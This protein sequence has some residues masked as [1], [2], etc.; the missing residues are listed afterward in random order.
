MSMQTNE[1]ESIRVPDEPPA[2]T[3]PAQV[4]DMQLRMPDG[5]KLQRKFLRSNTLGDI[6]NFVKKQKSG[7]SQV[8][9]VSTFPK[10][11][12]EDGS[13]TLDAAKFGKREALIVDAK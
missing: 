12:Y 13:L 4:V 2:N 11:V 5:S 1:V 10:K 9:L 6:F 7:L 3:D 8:K